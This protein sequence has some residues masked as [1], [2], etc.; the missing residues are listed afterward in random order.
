M[1]IVIKDKNGKYNEIEA[2][3]GSSKLVSVSNG[4]G[5]AI[6]NPSKNISKILVM[7]DVAW[8]PNNEEMFNIKFEDYDFEK[9]KNS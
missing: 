9:W 6:I 5:A 2:N 3:S 4:I 8:K 1:I 7:A